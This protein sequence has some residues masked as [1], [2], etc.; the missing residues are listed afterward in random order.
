MVTADLI[1]FGLLAF[2][3][4]V[5]ALVASRNQPHHQRGESP[6]AGDP[7]ETNVA[8]EKS[9]AVEDGRT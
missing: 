9:G 6:L 5:V 4:V 3:V 8:G 2:V 7:A 1:K